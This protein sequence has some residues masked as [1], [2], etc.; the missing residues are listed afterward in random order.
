MSKITDMQ[1]K[2]AA[3]Y[4]VATN[5]RSIKTHIFKKINKI[6]N[7]INLMTLKIILKFKDMDDPETL[8]TIYYFTNYKFI[9]TYIKDIKNQEDKLLALVAKLALT[10]K[11]IWDM[12]IA[13]EE[14]LS[15]L[16]ESI[17]QKAQD[18]DREWT[19]K[20]RDTWSHE[21]GLACLAT[22]KVIYPTEYPK[23]RWDS[24][25]AKRFRDGVVYAYEAASVS[26]NKSAIHKQQKQIFEEFLKAI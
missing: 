12:P 24:P 3:D 19:L 1:I 9:I 22:S 10:V 5:E 17:K 16:D 25:L 26:L 8:S 18:A 4:F 23:M 21:Q 6:I 11:D 15:T 2:H 20:F 7:T 13:V 14:Y